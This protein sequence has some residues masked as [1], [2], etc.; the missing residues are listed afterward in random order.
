MTSS[1]PRLSRRALIT[2]SLT[3]AGASALAACTKS[4]PEVA[5]AAVAASGTPE[6]PKTGLALVTV[7]TAAGPSVRSARNGIATA[8]VVDGNL[9]VIDAGLGVTRGVSDA[10]LP[11]K[12]LKA[13]FLTHLH[14]DHIGE[15][16]AFIMWNW[17]PPVDGPTEP[18]R[19]VGPGSAGE[20]PAGFP[21]TINPAVPGTRATVDAILEAYAYDINIRVVDENRPPLNEMLLVDEITLP[22]GASANGTSAP[23]ME[24][25]EVY[26]DEH[27]RV[28]A[29][30]VD[31][32]P[33]FPAYGF[34]FETKYGTVVVSGDTAK[35][36]N[37]VTLSEG[38]DVLVHESVYL[39]FYEK[40]NKYSREFINH[41]AQSH[42]TPEEI[43]DIATRAGVGHVVLSHLAGVATDEE[44]ASGVRS[45][46]SGKVTVAADRQVFVF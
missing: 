26:R 44:W 16:P 37:M 41:L 46:Y 34:R 20:L 9:Y 25:F 33:V 3:V 5:P 32:P 11:T 24:P 40:Q 15:L 18:I 12:D 43:G 23:A 21:T 8:L 13:I 4:D 27:V 22:E 31:H 1:S 10:K 45:T 7:G 35:T 29:T 14:S 42:T 30:L 19:I 39:P 17:G 36:D 38:A 6:I 28:L 2:A